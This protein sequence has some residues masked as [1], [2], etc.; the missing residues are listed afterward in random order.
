[1]LPPDDHVH[2]EWSWDAP[3]GS[4]EGSC[5][6]AVELGL[7]SIAFTEHVDMTRWVM[8]A[9]GRSLMPAERIGADDRFDPPAVDVD[10]YQACVERCRD[11][12]PDL[13]ILTGVELGE[14]HWFAGQAGAL[15]RA[16]DFQRVLGSLHSLELPDGAGG[17]WLV[18]HLFWA[19]APEGVAP[20][21]VVRAYLEEVLR[22][23]ESSDVF[24]VLAHID[25][26]VRGWPA[27]AGP[28]DPAD[29]EDEYRAVLRALAGSGRALEVNTRLPLAS[30]ILGWWHE[31]GGE[32]VSFGSDAHQP[33]LVAHGFATA[34]ALAESHGFHPGRHPHDF[35]RR[36]P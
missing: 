27:S 4:M 18:D 32:A 6:R 8:T 9:E 29:F 23:V 34:A 21:D 24:Q 7:P 12:F 5:A 30:E 13:R 20:A 26:P 28:F 22:M 15:L 17:P 11:R 33:A 25:Y 19:S 1:M 16:G 31:A 35:Y 10:G 36:H 14:P 2:T 3:A